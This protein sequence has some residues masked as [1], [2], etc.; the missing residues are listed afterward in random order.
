MASQ[1]DSAEN[2]EVFYDKAKKVQPRKA[3]RTK[4]RKTKR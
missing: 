4:A 1:N 3:T 2:N